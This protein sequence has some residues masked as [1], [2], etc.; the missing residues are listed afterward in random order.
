MALPVQIALPAVYRL[1]VHECE[2]ITAAGALDDD[3]VELIDGYLVK[4]MGK[5]PPHSWTAT[6]MLKSLEP[7]LPLGWT[8][9]HEQ[10]VQ[11]PEFDEPEPDIAIVRGTDDDSKRRIPK[12]SDVALLVEVSETTLERDRGEK[13]L[14][15][16]KGRI[17]IYWIV[18]LVDRQV[19][20][21]SDPGA[22]GCVSRTVFKLGET[23]PVMIDGR[24]VGLVA[25]ADILP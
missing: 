14:A 12:P 22:V 5:N 19:E 7:I 21:Y 23:V 4:K 10:P 11:I 16:A 9:R 8:W 15:Y 6:V 24:E 18:N 1:N 17:P 3:R 20:V 13:L 25:V 2:R